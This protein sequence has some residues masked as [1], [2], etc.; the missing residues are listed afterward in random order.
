MPKVKLGKNNSIRDICDVV[1]GNARSS[2]DDMARHRFRIVTSQGARHAYKLEQIFWTVLEVAASASGKRLGSYIAKLES[3]FEDGE[4]RTS[5]L[6]VHSM[7]W[8]CQTLAELS[9]QSVPPRVVRDLIAATPCPAFRVD[10][11]NRVRG[12]NQALLA[13]L[14]KLQMRRDP[15]AGGTLQVRF[16]RDFSSIHDELRSSACGSIEDNVEI[17]AGEISE[18][19]RIRI[20]Q[21]ESQDG[22]ALGMIV[23]ILD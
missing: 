12:H 14:A 1:A 9:S 18:T 8:I 3:K 15:D 10:K 17:R 23:F 21:I 20:V 11:N 5:H 4:N 7:L 13:R 22:N 16:D 6:R 19:W 2:E